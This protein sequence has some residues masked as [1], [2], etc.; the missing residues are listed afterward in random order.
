[1]QI[2]FQT[3]KKN[4]GNYIFYILKD[5]ESFK[6]KGFRSFL[7]REKKNKILVLMSCLL[8]KKFWKKTFGKDKL[9]LYYFAILSTTYSK[10]LY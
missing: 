1:M 9:V 7:G 4:N 5:I 2:Q 3:D 6:Y 10:S 8:K